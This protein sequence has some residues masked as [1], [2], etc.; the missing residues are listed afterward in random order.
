MLPH[1]LGRAEARP[2]IS[3]P[4][5]PYNPTG[6]QASKPAGS[7]ALVCQLGAQDTSNREI[8]NT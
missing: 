1:V 2:S 3:L 5:G 7:R 6:Y 8:G 4:D